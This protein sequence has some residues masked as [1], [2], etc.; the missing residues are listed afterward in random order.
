MPPMVSGRAVRISFPP[1]SRHQR[2]CG[3]R[4]VTQLSGRSLPLNA[5]RT[6]KAPAVGGGLGVVAGRSGLAWT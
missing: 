1:S 6:L 3:I 5:S 2:C 4:M